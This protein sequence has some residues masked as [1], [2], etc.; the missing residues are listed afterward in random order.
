MIA[1]FMGVD[2]PP[3]PDPKD[4]PTTA[5][6]QAAQTA[7]YRA[8]KQLQE[9]SGIIPGAA[10][11]EVQQVETPQMTFEEWVKAE[12]AATVKP[13]YKQPLVWIAVGAGLLLSLNA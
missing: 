2:A 5:D 13:W 8:M 1:Q 7:W 12:R 9:Q 6:F 4:Y 11:A 10:E 3:R